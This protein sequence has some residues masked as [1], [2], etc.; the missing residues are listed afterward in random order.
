MTINS[1]RQQVATVQ[2]SSGAGKWQQCRGVVVVERLEAN[3]EK[4]NSDN[5][6]LR[7]QQP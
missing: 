2:A 4:Y 5:Q 7:E 1:W 6:P 3:K